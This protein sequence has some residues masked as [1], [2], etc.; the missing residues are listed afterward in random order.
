MAELTEEQRG[1]IGRL[2]K[3]KEK[4]DPDMPNRG[5][6]FVKILKYVAEG[7]IPRAKDNSKKLEPRTDVPSRPRVSAVPTPVNRWK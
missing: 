2:W 5:F 4:I 7:K 3:E 1:M 6:S